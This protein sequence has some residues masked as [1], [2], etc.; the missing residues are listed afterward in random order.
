MSQYVLFGHLAACS[1][2]ST[3]GLGDPLAVPKAAPVSDAGGRDSALCCDLLVRA[4][5]A[6]SG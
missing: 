4:D 1:C 5:D 2:Q 6:R 3:G